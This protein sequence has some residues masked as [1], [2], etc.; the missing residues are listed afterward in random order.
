MPLYMIEFGYTPEAWAGLVKSPENREEAVRQALED[1]G[2][3]LHD[4]WYAFGENDGF[5]LI[6]APD[7]ITAGGLAIAIASSGAFR[8]FETHVLMTQ[9]EV[10]EALEK[11]GDIAYAA[12][13]AAVHA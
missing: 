5:A 4:L 1:A 3:K 13:G 10:L 7:T 9:G 8:K 11:A 12:P 6:E 2:C